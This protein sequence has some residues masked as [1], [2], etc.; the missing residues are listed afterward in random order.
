MIFWFCLFCKQSAL[1]RS[2][3]RRIFSCCKLFFLKSKFVLNNQTNFIFDL[4]LFALKHKLGLESITAVT[5]DKSL[6]FVAPVNWSYGLNLVQF[7]QCSQ[8]AVLQ[9]FSSEFFF[10]TQDSLN[11]GESIYLNI[12]YEIYDHIWWQKYDHQKN[13]AFQDK[14][15]IVKT[16][17][18]FLLLKTK[19]CFVLC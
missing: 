12:F 6:I 1:K 5:E 14:R 8:K 2:L 18:L 11:F 10:C 3:T 16:L 9:C 19:D 17:S 13:L 7:L 15:N 4:Y